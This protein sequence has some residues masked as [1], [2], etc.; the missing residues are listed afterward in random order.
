MVNR[1]LSVK[2][3]VFAS[4]GWRLSVVKKTR[5]LVSR[6]NKKATRSTLWILRTVLCVILSWNARLLAEAAGA[7]MWVIVSGPWT[8]VWNLSQRRWFSTNALSPSW[9][10]LWNVIHVWTLRLFLW[11]PW[12]IKPC[13]LHWSLERLILRLIANC[14]WLT[15]LVLHTTRQT[16]VIPCKLLCWT[17]WLST[18]TISM[19]C[20]SV[21][22]L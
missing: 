18:K 3:L 17:V 11:Q 21:C 4:S 7:T 6:P 19:N 1:L 9:W 8:V 20:W 15:A 22:T 5:H 2:S 14:I 13:C 10:R 12:V 16:H